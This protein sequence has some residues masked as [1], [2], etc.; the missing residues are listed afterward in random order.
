VQLAF[1][2]AMLGVNEKV[3]EGSTV[4]VLSAEPHGLNPSG[5]MNIGERIGG[6]ENEVGA[7][8][9][10]ARRLGCAC[11]QTSGAHLS[12]HWRR[13][14]ASPRDPEYGHACPKPRDEKAAVGV[15]DAALR[16]ICGIERRHGKNAIAFEDYDLSQFFAARNVHN[17]DVNDGNGLLCSSLRVE[18]TTGCQAQYES[19]ERGA[20]AHL[21]SY[22][23]RA[24]RH[25]TDRSCCIS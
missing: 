4:E 1:A 15:N 13:K 12:L 11:C 2:G 19:G 18:R 10:L 3:I 25:V 24:A 6:E 16:R 7:L 17:G 22:D 14:A 23:A 8:A 21:Y 20:Q 5:V 9:I